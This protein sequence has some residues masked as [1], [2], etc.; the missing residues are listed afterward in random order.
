MQ[1]LLVGA[2]APDRITFGGA[3]TIEIY[4]F[5]PGESVFG[6]I[7]FPHTYKEETDIEPHIHF[8]PTTA[9]VGNLKWELEYYWLNVGGSAAGSPTT[10]T[11]EVQTSGTAWVS[12]IAGFDAVVGTGK[13][14]SSQLVF[15]L[16]RV[17]AS[18]DEFTGDGALMEFDC[19][20]KVDAMGSYLEFTK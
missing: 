20:H 11:T 7:Q 1:S 13:L 18:S 15:R 19:H 2:A 10:I 17:A 8:C 3:G 16:G 9:D 4:G 6:T 12:A 14:I 5:A